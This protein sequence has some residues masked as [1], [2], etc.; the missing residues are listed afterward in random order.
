MC[1][2]LYRKKR[3]LRYPLLMASLLFLLLM[4]LYAVASAS[5]P[6]ILYLFWGEGCPHCEEEKEFLELLYQQYPELEMRW[7]EIWDHPEFAKLADAMRES[8][9]EKMTLIP[10]TFIGDRVIIGFRS[11]EETGV[12]IQEQVKA[13]LE[14]GCRDALDTIKPQP[15]IKKIKEEAVKKRPDGWEL[16]PVSPRKQ[17]ES[18]AKKTE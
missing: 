4:P 5:D 11:Y 18:Q 1:N 15:V 17:E 12:Q 7:F 16:F 13:C 2:K 9:G 3:F 10:M 6:P 14:E 8:Y